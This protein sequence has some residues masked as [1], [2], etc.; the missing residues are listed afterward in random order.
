MRVAS[1]IAVRIRILG[2]EKLGKSSK[3]SNLGGVKA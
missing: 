3:I 2:K 1:E